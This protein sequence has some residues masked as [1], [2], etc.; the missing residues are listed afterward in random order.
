MHG[1]CKIPL[2][3]VV[4]GTQKIQ[5]LTKNEKNPLGLQE[6]FPAIIGDQMTEVYLLQSTG[7]LLG[8]IYSLSD[9]HKEKLPFIITVLIRYPQFCNLPRSYS[10]RSKSQ[11]HSGMT[12]PS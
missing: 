3:A 10:N 7:S 9:V 2:Q 5:Y 1:N 6:H 11:L 12:N 8:N 4:S